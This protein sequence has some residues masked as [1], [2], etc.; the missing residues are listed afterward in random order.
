MT[1][2]GQE[3]AAGPLKEPASQPHCPL[4]P[5]PRKLPR[6]RNNCV[7]FGFSLLILLLKL[8]ASGARETGHSVPSSLIGL[9]LFL[10]VPYCGKNKITCLISET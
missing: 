2:V 1:S 10:K 8:E 3:S 9:V 5:T 4:G 6:E 7:T